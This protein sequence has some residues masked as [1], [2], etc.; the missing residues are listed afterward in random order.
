MWGW[1]LSHLC[2]PL[3]SPLKTFLVL[4]ALAYAMLHRRWVRRR[5]LGPKAVVAVGC[6]GAMV[7]SA[8]AVYY[9]S[10]PFIYDHVEATLAVTSW[11]YRTGLPLY[12]DMVSSPDRY[13]LLYGPLCFLANSAVFAVLGPSL[14]AAKLLGPITVVTACGLMYVLCARWLGRRRA[15]LVV[16]LLPA[17]FLPHTYCTLSNRPDGPMM[18]SVALA[19]VLALPLLERRQLSQVGALLI[20][21][22]MGLAMSCKL[23]GFLYFA[24]IVGALCACRRFWAMAL[25][26]SAASLTTCAFFLFDNVSA[27]HYLQVLKMVSRHPLSW[28]EFVDILTWELLVLLPL[29]AL[30]LRLPKDDRPGRGFAK[31]LVVANLLLLGFAAKAG[32][33]RHHVLPMLPC[34][35]AMLAWLLRHKVEW[36]ALARA[37]SAVLARCWSR[38]RLV[39][40]RPRVLRRRLDRRHRL[41]CSRDSRDD[42]QERATSRAEGDGRASPLLPNHPGQRGDGRVRGELRTGEFPRAQCLR[43]GQALDRGSGRNGFRTRRAASAASRVR[44]PRELYVSLLAHPQRRRAVLDVQS[45]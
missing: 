41:W 10:R 11:A 5:W 18:L 39:S 26:L 44:P 25:L 29:L 6:A 45:G 37:F 1:I 28:N 15:W 38:Q 16:G 17:L 33:G 32:A 36:S 14:L 34:Y 12:H 4:S 20:G 2:L 7:W 27:A 13:A 9:L 23:H 43:R 21:A 40:S 3:F 19:L 22:C 35:G 30:A 8:L 24:P 42:H 31:G